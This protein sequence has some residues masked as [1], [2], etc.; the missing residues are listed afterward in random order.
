LSEVKRTI[1]AI[2]DP[3]ASKQPVR[4]ST[5]AGKLRRTAVFAFAVAGLVLGHALAY[6][7]AMPDPHHRDLVLARTGHDYL[8]TAAQLGLI[9]AFAAAAAAA[10]G[11]I[12]SRREVASD[13]WLTLAMRLAVVQASAFA[14]QEVVERI[15]TGAPLADLVHQHLLVAGLAA[16]VVVAFAGSAVLRW[17]ARSAA[18]L[19]DARWTPLPIPRLAPAFAFPAANDVHR[20]RDAHRSSAQRAPPL[21]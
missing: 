9:L 16:Q 15:A 19:A 7:L 3:T 1:G 14:G 20:H 11:G 10:A 17:I 13:R 18:R 8:P 6:V 12:L 4:N 21:R 2:R 5:S